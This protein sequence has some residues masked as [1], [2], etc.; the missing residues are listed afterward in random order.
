[1]PVAWKEL[2]IVFSLNELTQA[3]Q[4][5]GK[6][7]LFLIDDSPWLLSRRADSSSE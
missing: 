5:G 6:K 7:S 2:V 4:N 3:F 1:M